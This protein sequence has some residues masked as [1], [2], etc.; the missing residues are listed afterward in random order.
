MSSYWMVCFA[1]L[2]TASIALP[3]E[4]GA[5]SGLSKSPRVDRDTFQKNFD[6]SLS[7][8]RESR[9]RLE[10]TDRAPCCGGGETQQHPDICEINSDLPQCRLTK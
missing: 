5:Q 9:D 8:A 2:A 10:R 3:T 7:R 6:D 1:C 4:T